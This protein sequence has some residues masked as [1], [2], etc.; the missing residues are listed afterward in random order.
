MVPPPTPAELHGFGILR[1]AGR[2]L[3]G[4]ANSSTPAWLQTNRGIGGKSNMA[5]LRGF[6]PPTFGSDCHK[7]H[8]VFG[9]FFRDEV[10]KLTLG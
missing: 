2:T 8:L 9:P 7:T 1:M 4:Q 3:V 6:E 5:C 10:P